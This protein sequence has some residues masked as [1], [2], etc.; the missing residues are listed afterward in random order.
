M[1]IGSG[2]AAQIGIGVETTPGTAVTP[3]RFLRFSS[4]TL[5]AKKK[6][7]QQTTLAAGQQF[8]RTAA[9]FTTQRWATGDIMLPVP[10]KG[11]GL[12]LQQ[13]LGSFTATATQQ[14]TTT[15]YLQTHTPGIFTGHT[16]SVQKGAPRT[17][18]TVEPYTYPGCKVTSWE[19]DIAQSE[20]LQAKLTVDAWDELTSGTTP[21][22]PALA[23]ASFAS[24]SY[25]SFVSGT[26]LS[27]GTVATASG[28]T[29]VTGGTAVAAI[30]AANVKGNN[31]SDTTRYFLG[32]GTTKAEQVQNAVSSV[33]GQLTA[34]FAN[35]TLYDQ[36]RSDG[37]AAVQLNFS[38]GLIA[39]GYN[40]MLNI[41]MPSVFLD[42]GASPKIPGP[43]IITQTIPFAAL[44]DDTNPVI[45]IQYQSTDTAL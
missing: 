10:T 33:T 45:Q 25:F 9:R 22:S 3:T 38:G 8:D 37:S 20:L 24:A 1:A 15:A 29:T 11:F 27:G 42:D 31:A 35:R 4:E 12:I 6:I 5:E 2:I 18:G 34:E 39:T 14:A 36:Y 23:T 32:A 30:T 26:I 17:D 28:V 40:Y 43:G 21:A 13:M 16:F 44:S 7:V 19:L 41:V